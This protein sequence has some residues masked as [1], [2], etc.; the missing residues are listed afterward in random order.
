[1]PWEAPN[2]TIHD[3]EM[4]TSNTKRQNGF[5]LIELMVVISIIALLAGGGVA[6][7][8]SFNKTQTLKA[9]AN[10]LKNNLRLAQSKALSQ[11]KPAGCS[12]LNGYQVTI[13]PSSYSIQAF[14]GVESPVPCGATQSFL[15]ASGVSLS[16]SSTIRF[17]VLK[18][19]ATPAA[20]T[21]SGFGKTPLIMTVTKTGEIY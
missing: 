17:W 21:I 16:P 13:A 6:A 11:E 12:C 10:D 8:S 15:V 20:I 18:G 1:M 7:F 4:Q 14:C 2:I 19:G 5:T 9:A 3:V